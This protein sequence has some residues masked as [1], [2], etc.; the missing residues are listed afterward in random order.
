MAGLCEKHER[1]HSEDAN[2]RQLSC[3]GAIWELGCWRP[4]GSVA[5][6]GKR[7]NLVGSREHRRKRLAAIL[8]VLTC[9]HNQRA[10][11]TPQGATYDL[12]SA[13]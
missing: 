12:W 11:R 5:C 10:W 9:G 1:E 8:G 2:P 6:G 4:T 3:R 13:Q 7:R